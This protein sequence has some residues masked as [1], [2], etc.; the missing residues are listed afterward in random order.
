[1]VFTN[2]FLD[3]N[4]WLDYVWYYYMGEGKKKNTKIEL[5]NSFEDSEHFVIFTP[6]LIAEIST[7]LANWY[8]MKK[9]IQSGHSYR[10]FAKERKNHNLNNKEKA[11]IDTVI[12]KISL[13]NFV[14]VITIDEI[15]KH[16]LDILF[17]LINN[18]AEL[19]DSIHI[20]I[21]KSAN[22]DYFVTTDDELRLRT[23]PLV[24]N[25]TIPKKLK[26]IRPQSLKSVLEHKKKHLLNF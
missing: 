18:Q 20:V 14:N 22:C 23:Q 10:E 15:K 11:E 25:G 3:T 26:L 7:H 2:I 21:A 1:M 16:D 24:N 5:I 19:Y 12:E 17:A 9:V 13:K 6:F 8:L 4:I